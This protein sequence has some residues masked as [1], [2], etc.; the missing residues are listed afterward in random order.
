MCAK[1]QIDRMVERNRRYIE[2]YGNE[3]QSHVA[4]QQ[5]YAAVLTCSDSR[6][7]P[8]LIF[9]AGLGELFVVRDAGNLAMGA[10]VMGSLEYAVCHLH[11]PL[12]LVMGHTNCGALKAAEKGPGDSSSVGIIVDEIRCCFGGEDPLRDNVRRQEEMILERSPA[13]AE[14]V[15][16]GVLTI[17]GA[18]Y[19][20]ENGYVEFL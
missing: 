8:E 18:V 17:Q 19:H 15:R 3:L 7:S 12:L 16:S 1:E 20:L 2:K 13:I 6:V 11:V 5:P 9:N 14:A 10:S 4:G